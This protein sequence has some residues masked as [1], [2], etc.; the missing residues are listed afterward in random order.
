MAKKVVKKS[1]NKT[2]VKKTAAK[3]KSVKK[4]TTKKAVKKAVSPNKTVK[5][6]VSVKKTAKKKKAF[7]KVK[8]LDSKTLEHFRDL[9]LAKRA[10]LFGDVDLMENETLR[11][12][13]NDAAGDLSSMPIHMADMGTDNYEQEF[14]LGLLDSE[15][16]IIREIDEALKKIDSGNYGICQ[17]TGKLIKRVRLE[18]KPWAK[19]CVEYA[20][21]VEQGLVVEG[22]KVE[23]YDDYDDEELEKDIG[24][25]QEEKFDDGDSKYDDYNSHVDQDEDEDDDQQMS[26]E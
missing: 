3:K 14:A 22:E 2:S 26:Y 5:K 17:G 23:D 13:R 12:S 10:E 7:P 18:A 1:K 6:A 19:Y 8:K 25:F 15:R 4:K 20:K 24:D 16:R 11:K 9:L 21:M